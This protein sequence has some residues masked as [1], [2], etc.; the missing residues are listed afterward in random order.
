MSRDEDINGKIKDANDA[1]DV[2]CA[3]IGDTEI[4]RNMEAIAALAK[5][6]NAVY[7]IARIAKGQ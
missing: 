2:L 1:F 4:P 5:I 7:S 6:L 3:A